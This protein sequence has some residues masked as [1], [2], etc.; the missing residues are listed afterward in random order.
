MEHMKKKVTLNREKLQEKE[1][2][3]AMIHKGQSFEPFQGGKKNT[4]EEATMEIGRQEG[5]QDSNATVEGR[6]GS[7]EKGRISWS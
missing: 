1:K 2:G 5:V 3:N 4:R 6:G 7:F